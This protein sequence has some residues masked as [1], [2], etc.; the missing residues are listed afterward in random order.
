MNMMRPAR[1]TMSDFYSYWRLF[2]R[3]PNVGRYTVLIA[4]EGSAELRAAKKLHAAEYL[5]RGF[6]E[7][8]DIFDEIIHE[9]SDPY[10]KHAIYFVVKNKQNVVGVARQIIYKGTGEMKESFPIL[11]KANIY[12]RYRA[13]IERQHPHTIVEISALVKRRGES[14]IVPIVL[15]RSLWQYSRKHGHDFWI[16]ACDVRL[17]HRLRL[18]FGPAILKIGK[19]TPYF[20]GD[21]V[22]SALHIPSSEY[23]L[24]QHTLKKHKLFT[25]RNRAASHML[26]EDKL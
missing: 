22:P 15:Y 11:V 10:Q 6:I 7:E 9:D 14:S 5:A 12:S 17:Y 2:K 4:E 16:M 18:L 25:I 24:R 20:G 23:Y 13:K 8:N 19:T 1:H 3:E 21:V 26:R